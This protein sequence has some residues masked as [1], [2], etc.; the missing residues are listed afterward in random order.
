MYCSPGKT[1]MSFKL[2]YTVIIIFA[3]SIVLWA[4]SSYAPG[5]KFK[6]IEK[7]WAG[8]ENAQMHIATAKLEASYAGMIGKNLLLLKFC[9]FKLIPTRSY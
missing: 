5:N 7:Q 1:C 2:C 9:G 3:I 8:S 4:L 6:Q